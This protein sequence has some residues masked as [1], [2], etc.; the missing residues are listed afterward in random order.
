MTALKSKRYT[1]TRLQRMLTHIY[2]GVTKQQLHAFKHPSY[3]RVL[4]MTAK[5]QAYISEKKKSLSLPLISRVAAISDP[6]LELDLHA[7]LMYSIGIA[8]F[9][10]K[11]IDEDYK[12][13]PIR[14]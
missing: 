12:T 13:P 6:L 2:T 10:H 8:Q 5:G 3:I 9:S 14:V 1:W 11:K 4:G 7:T